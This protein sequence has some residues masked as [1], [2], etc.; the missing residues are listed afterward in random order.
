MKMKRWIGCLC[1]AMLVLGMSA[2]SKSADE[3]KPADDGQKTEQVETEQKTDVNLSEVYTLYDTLIQD[4]KYSVDNYNWQRAVSSDLVTIDRQAALCDINSDGVPELFL[5]EA[6]NNHQADL[7]IYTVKD[8]E[9]VEMK[10]DANGSEALL[11]DVQA[12]AGVNYVVF[13]GKDGKFYI[14]RTS[15]D[16]SITYRVCAYTVDGTTLKQEG[17]LE[18]EYGPS[19]D[20]T[21]EISDE[22][23][24][25]GKK[26]TVKL[27][28]KLFHES[29]QNLDK[30]ILFSGYDETSI[31]SC[32]DMDSALS[33]S[34]DDMIAQLEKGMDD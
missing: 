9:T 33:V 30:A 13:T 26:I 24:R 27:G 16:S 2:C 34:S 31:W 4:K 23:S 17:M 22:Y 15:G 11:S 1:V 7:H 14:Y 29:F 5:M 18:N 28:K 25:N 6:V 32:F 8:G 3:D 21:N 20:N 10:S 12:G 19:E